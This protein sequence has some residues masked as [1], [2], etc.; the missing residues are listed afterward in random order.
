MV[1]QLTGWKGFTGFQGI[2]SWMSVVFLE[3]QVD[4]D[5]GAQ[6]RLHQWCSWAVLSLFVS[7][8]FSLFLTYFM[9]ELVVLSVCTSCVGDYVGVTWLIIT[10]QTLSFGSVVKSLMNKHAWTGLSLNSCFLQSLIKT[11][12]IQIIPN[13]YKNMNW[14]KSNNKT[15]I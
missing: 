11:Y 2:D 12:E 3:I 5:D 8:I 15:R 7:F 14:I 4:V 1:L 9:L 10:M 13:T 6:R